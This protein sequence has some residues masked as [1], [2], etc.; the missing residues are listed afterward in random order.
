MS[1]TFFKVKLS[2]I[3]ADHNR[4]QV[5]TVQ[6]KK[7][8]LFQTKKMKSKNEDTPIQKS[9]FQLNSLD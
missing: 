1:D 7:I 5:R 6:S 2:K 8:F 4:K 9:K 3:L